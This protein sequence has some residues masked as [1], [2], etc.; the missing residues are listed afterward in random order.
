MAKSKSFLGL[1]RGST[2]SLT[3]SVLDGQQITKDRVYDVK[4]PR[5]EGQMRQRMLMTTVGAAYKFM[6]SIA[7]HSFEGKTSGM[8]CMRE[9]NSK[10]L[11]KFKA[12]A[13]ADGNVAFNEF[14]D[15][16]I[17][18]LPF[19]LSAG[20]LAG[21][22]YSIAEDKKLTLSF[23]KDDADTATAEGIYALMGVNKGDL[24]TFCTIIGA[25]SLVN[26]VLDYNPARFDVVRL[27]C[28]KSGAVASIADAFTISTNN[29]NASVEFS[30][31]ENGIT[32][33]SVECNFG[34]VI[35]SRKSDTNWL[36]SNAIMVVDNTI[37]N[38]VKT[39][40][41]LGTY[42][43]G[44]DL[45]LNNGPMQNGQSTEALPAP[46]LSFAQSSINANGTATVN[47]PKLQGIPSGATVSYASQ[48][49]S[50]ATVDAK[51]GVVQPVSN[52]TAIIVATTSATNEYAA[53]KAHFSVVV[54][55]IV[56]AEGFNPQTLELEKN[57]AKTVTLKTP[58]VAE[59]K[60][61][62][63][64]SNPST[65]ESLNNYSI[66][67]VDDTK[68]NP[69]KH[70]YKQVSIKCSTTKSAESAALMYYPE[71]SSG[72]YYYY[73]KNAPLTISVTEGGNS[74]TM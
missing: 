67:A 48:N 21:F 54:S 49:T 19:V 39:A 72:E 65:D 3:F 60:L 66:E 74:A 69:G 43:I 15:G 71:M 17:N 16:G 52:G 70:T 26:G 13:A 44:T 47:A 11:N 34:A 30:T 37:L 18:P 28:D 61:A 31:I 42:P 1:R 41:Q 58:I 64:L 14:K 25:A 2:K 50:V 5:T 36:R 73:G 9:F 27:Y 46:S 22:D 63:N 10:N 12:A 8:Q 40:N 35:Q 7:D 23:T 6:K 51:T 53:G 32:I 56:A 62:F 68:T 55:G 57:V 29:L 33:K 59:N 20:S 45:I 24:V 38:G 4:N